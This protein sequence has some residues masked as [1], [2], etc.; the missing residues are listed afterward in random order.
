MPMEIII[1]IS[2]AAT[3]SLHAMKT[4]CRCCCLICTICYMKCKSCGYIAK[5]MSAFLVSSAN[6]LRLIDSGRSYINDSL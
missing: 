5:K 3:S 1:F 4:I 6:F 2:D